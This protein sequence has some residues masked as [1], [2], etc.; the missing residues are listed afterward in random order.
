[1]R[2][3]MT[4]GRSPL[5][6]PASE[7]VDDLRQA[8]LLSLAPDL[9]AV[10]GA[11][12]DRLQDQAARLGLAKL[13]RIIE[14]IGLAQVDMREAPDPRVVLEVAMARVSRAEL[15]PSPEALA[16][17]VTRL[18]QAVGSNGGGIPASS[19]DARGPR[20]SGEA[21]HVLV[22]G[23]PRSRPALGALRAAKQPSDA[24]ARE[25]SP[26]PKEPPLVSGENLG[27]LDRDSLV[28]AWGDHVLAALPARAKALYSSGRFVESEE[29][30]ALFAVPSTAYL[31]RCEEVRPIVEEALSAHF[32][33]AVTLD[34]VAESEETLHGPSAGRT[35][36]A[37][38]DPAALADDDFDPSDPGEPMEVDKL[39]RSRLLQAFP[40]AEEV[41]G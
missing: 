5:R 16:E 17:R 34:L 6:S 4:A 7:V 37:S 38:Q 13:V 28:E 2:A 22:G 18:E 21:R 26:P 8:F 41:Q 27:A 19:P 12:R 15:D 29:A 40:G 33:V 14:S 3:R 25:P 36:A 32:G 24:P 1:V 10:D 30:R 11:E 23:D 39:V 35:Q 9:A 31:A 20:I